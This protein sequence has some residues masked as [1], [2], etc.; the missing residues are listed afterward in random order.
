MTSMKTNLYINTVSISG[1]LVCVLGY[2]RTINSL[3][4][5][6]LRTIA[7]YERQAEN[8]PRLPPSEGVS[9]DWKAGNISE[10]FRQLVDAIPSLTFVS[11]S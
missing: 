7:L 4:P 9:A 2:Q 8:I 6:E 11:L 1:D 3:T 5:E 10:N